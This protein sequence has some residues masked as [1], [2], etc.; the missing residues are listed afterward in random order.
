M[1]KGTPNLTR[2]GII[3]LAILTL[4]VGIAIADTE[5]LTTYNPFTGKLDYYT[6]NST[7]YSES[8]PLWESN[9]TNGI[10]S[11]TGTLA[12]FRE[13]NGTLSWENITNYPV[14]CP[15]N[16][17]LTQLDDS[18]TCTEVVDIPN[19]GNATFNKLYNVSKI[20][21]F[22][23]VLKG[24]STD[25]QSNID[26]CTSTDD[27][28]IYIPSGTYTLT[29][30]LVLKS[31]IVL[32]GAN[33]RR[34]DIDCSGIVGSCIK[35]TPGKRIYNVEIQNIQILGDGDSGTI[36]FDLTNISSSFIKNIDI[37]DFEKGIACISGYC[38]YNNFY[39]VSS[40]NS[41]Y[42]YFFNNSANENHFFGG[43]STGS[44]EYMIWVDN[45]NNN[46]FNS[47][48]FEGSNE[49]IYLGS[50]SYSIG[51]NNCRYE[52]TGTS[53]ITINGN[54]NQ[55]IGGRMSST[56]IYDNAAGTLI[57]IPEK[58]YTLGMGVQATTNLRLNDF[59]SGQTTETPGISIN[60]SYSASGSPSGINIYLG[61]GGGNFE[62]FQSYGITKW[63]LDYSGKLL[64]TPS[65]Q[66][67]PVFN[68]TSTG[69]SEN[70]Q[71]HPTMLIEDLYSA[72][73]NPTTLRLNLNRQGGKF[74]TS[75]L[76]GTEK[77][78]V[79]VTNGDI[80][81]AGNATIGQNLTISGTGININSL[82]GITGNYT[83]GDCWTYYQGGIAVSTNCTAI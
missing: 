4:S 21:S 72:A 31:D 75:W 45:S 74:I 78:Y 18:V 60:K 27:C 59:T 30:A 58:G 28:R 14:A 81:T 1:L 26:D 6:L 63:L 32:I 19:G 38:Y 7:F 54:N 33:E 8:D 15:A 46:I 47:V 73:G 77:F 44:D 34:V 20:N 49:Q 35:A 83:N 68:L 52:F 53:N 16:S 37:D 3:A 36:G 10:Y 22:R 40:R 82:E 29:S 9:L 69:T 2:F 76:S 51:L 61:R 66:T 62:R 56:T 67:G 65:Q 17:Y 70:D 24:N 39:D 5:F 12:V 23:W 41:N 57:L 64:I 11:I 55:L 48:S 43:Y 50:G 13:L 80:W 79:G 71:D 42:N 25:L